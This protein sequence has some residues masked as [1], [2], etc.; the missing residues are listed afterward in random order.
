MHCTGRSGFWYICLHHELPLLEVIDSSCISKVLVKEWLKL[1]FS[2]LCPSCLRHCELYRLHV[3]HTCNNVITVGIFPWPV[4]IFTNKY[5]QQG[6]F[7]LQ[8]QQPTFFVWLDL[9]FVGF[10]FS[11]LKAENLWELIELITPGKENK[12]TVAFQFTDITWIAKIPL[13]PRNLE[14]KDFTGRW[15]VCW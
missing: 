1:H 8:W 3:Q 12:W 14:H 11:F 9:F 6:N 2:T 15:C 13:L 10:D 5:R 7:Y 4:L